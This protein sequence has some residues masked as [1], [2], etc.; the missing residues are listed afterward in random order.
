MVLSQNNQNIFIC[1]LISIQNILGE[2]MFDQRLYYNSKL[3]YSIKGI[4]YISKNLVQIIC[5]NIGLLKKCLILDL[6][7]T[8]WGGVIGDDGINGIDLG[9]E[10]LGAIYL[11][12]QQW[13]L[14]L[15]NRGIILAVCSKNTEE[16]AK[17]VF[18]KHPNMLI[19]MED[20]SIFKVNWRDKTDN[21]LE[22]KE[23]LNIDLNSIV[24]IDDSP[25]ERGL[26]R[27]NLPSVTVAEL[28]DDPSNY[29]E[30]LRNENYFEVS[31]ITNADLE[32]T[33]LYKEESQRKKSKIKF[34]SNNAF[35]KSLKMIA[36]I[37]TINNYNLK[38][39]FQLIQKTNQFNTTNRR[40]SQ[41]KIKEIIATKNN[42]SKVISLK[43]NY[44]DYGIISCIILSK[45]QDNLIIDT[46]IMSCRVFDRQIENFSFNQII[47]LAKS[48]KCKRIICLYKPTKRI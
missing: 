26:V 7:N 17:E 19:K 4:S 40:Y 3:A 1:D 27:R 29:L 38:R 46:W 21:I 28:P 23:D 5:S 30:Y 43:D 32:K 6:D 37:D 24:F 33:K 36:K 25:F 44:G 14:E 8:L 22:I 39:V 9:G 18:D 31:S 15:K 16:I 2:N 41:N 35:L 11:E 13:I 12:I 48:L 10:G 45:I 20:I 47:K 42:Y 34:K